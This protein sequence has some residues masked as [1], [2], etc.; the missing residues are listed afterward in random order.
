MEDIL[1]GKEWVGKTPLELFPAEIAEAMIADDR[2]AL[3]R[4]Y[5]RI[6]E[7]VADAGGVEHVYETHKFPIPRQEKPALLGGISLDITERKL[8][9]QELL[10][11]REQLRALAAE[12]S[13]AEERER[14]Q[15]AAYLH[16]HIGQALAVL[17][18]KFGALTT[19]A[20]EG[21]FAQLIA[22]IRDLLEQAIGDTT[23]LT[24]DLSPPILNELGLVPAI[25]WVGEKTCG[26][27]GLE[28]EF[29]DDGEPKP[30]EDD[31]APL[32]F[33]STRELLMNVVKHASAGRVTLSIVRE[34]SSVCVTVEDDGVGLESSRPFSPPGEG[35]FGL[36]S[37][38]E[39]TQFIGGR[40]SIESRP[41]R[42][43]RAC[44]WMPLRRAEGASGRVGL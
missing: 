35:G 2:R 27:H 3:S 25:E 5:R 9:E 17:R 42:G 1:G 11:S 37:I 34:G 43:T 16:D 7:A 33:R 24:F 19:V 15:L 21:E 29:S 44:V 26:E 22:G 41:G 32:L 18:M 13:S 20:D 23:S 14:R 36:Y 38:R 4:G 28:L 6:E 12:L 8:A 10:A 40:F 30:L 39:R 31:V